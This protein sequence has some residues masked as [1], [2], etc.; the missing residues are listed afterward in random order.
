VGGRDWIEWHRDY[1]DPTSPHSWRLGVVQAG[2]RSRLDA[3]PDGPIRLLSLCAG[4]GRDVL[5]VLADHPRAADVSA[6]LVE[7]DAE[8]SERARAGVAAAGLGD[9]VRVVTGDAG[10]PRVWWDG[11]PVDVLL[12]CGIFGNVGD[13]DI[14]HTVRSLPGLCAAGG[15]VLWTRHRRPPDLTPAVRRWFADAG[16]AELSWESLGEDGPSVGVNRFDGVPRA[17]ALDP[18]VPLFQFV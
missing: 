17:D 13:D 7:L 12:L 2:L 9:A 6:T 8:L 3:A 16:F 1:D 14:A 11:T 5:G 15:S 18:A 10:D 4:D